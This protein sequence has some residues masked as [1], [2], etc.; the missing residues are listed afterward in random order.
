[1]K[2]VILLWVAAVLLAGCM[3]LGNSF[4]PAA[5]DQ[6]TPNVSTVTDA[7]Q[8]MGPPT[9]DITYAS[10]TRLLQWSYAKSSPLGGKG[11]GVS[12]LFDQGGYM[13]QVAG[14]SNFKI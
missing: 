9:N 11:H 13:L 14:R 8:L 4:D 7:I 6:L 3:T 1:M 12:V 5:V 10:G 2:N